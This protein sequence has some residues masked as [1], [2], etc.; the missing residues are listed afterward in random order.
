MQNS[1]SL[2][3]PSVTKFCAR[4]LCHGPLHGVLPSSGGSPRLLHTQR[5]QVSNSYRDKLDSGLRPKDPGGSYVY[6]MGLGLQVMQG[7]WQV[8]SG[9]FN[10]GLLMTLLS[11]RCSRSTGI[12]AYRGFSLKGPDTL[13]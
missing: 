1:C 9:L 6:F 13:V 5:V 10:S 4:S 3:P 2:Q 7:R 12:P 8:S 11:A